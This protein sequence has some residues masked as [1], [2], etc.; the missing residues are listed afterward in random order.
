MFL[1]KTLFCT[2]SIQFVNEDDGGLLLLGESEG[3][4]DELGAVTDEHLYELGT[5]QLQEGRL[6]LGGTGS[7]QQGLS[8]TRRSIQQHTLGETKK[9]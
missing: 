1:Q 6:G 8:C 3:I 7:S 2:N 9:V 5:S 4:S